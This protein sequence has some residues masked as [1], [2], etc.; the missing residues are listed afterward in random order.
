MKNISILGSTGSIGVSALDIVRTHPREFCVKALAAHRNVE[1]LYDQAREFLPEVVCLYDREAA[2]VL[3]KRLGASLVKV[4]SGDDGLN[5]VATLTSVDQAVFAMVGACGLLPIF[6]AMRAGKALAIANKEPLV[7]AGRLLMAEARRLKVSVFPIDSEHSG[8]W[9]CLEGR[10]PASIKKLML[11]SSGG[12][13]R[14]KLSGF[15]KITPKSA[16]N[17]PKWKMGPK[18]TIDSATLM[19]KGLE[20]IEAA[21][22]FGVSAD[23]I[24]VLIHPEAVVHAMVEFV[25]GTYLANM[26]ITDMRLPIQYALSYPERLNNHLPVLDLVRIGALHFEKPDFKRFPCLRLA[27]EAC[28]AGGD[29]PAVLNAANEVAVELFLSKRIGFTE[30]PNLIAKV[31]KKHKVN[32]RPQLTDLLEIDRWARGEASVSVR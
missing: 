2:A 5:T 1:A 31:M 7:I 14:N 18:I 8:L 16:L 15:D 12:P 24:E 26:G 20:V 23:N 19:N 10:A 22:L 6:A 4:V 21:N 30:I 32:S 3:E 29:M 11:T 28:E 17:H 27:Y 13:F 25:D 9:Q